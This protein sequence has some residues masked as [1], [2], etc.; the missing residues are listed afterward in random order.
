MRCRKA[1]LTRIRWPYAPSGS[2]RCRGSAH[3]GAVH[4]D[5]GHLEIELSGP[6]RREDRSS[7]FQVVGYV[8]R[9]NHDLHDVPEI[10]VVRIPGEG[11]DDVTL[12]R[13]G[14]SVPMAEGGDRGGDHDE[15]PRRPTR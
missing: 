15:T 11:V 12:T 10:A 6:V 14:G 9:V 5:R 7:I 4:V 2:R 8:G 1:A 13:N 3:H